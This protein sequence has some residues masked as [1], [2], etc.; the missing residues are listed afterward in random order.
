MRGWLAVAALG[1]VFLTAPA[2]GQRRGGGIS[3]GFAGHGGFASR[4]PAFGGRGM[5]MGN[6]GFGG[7]HQS[8]G[9]GAG[10]R[11]SRYSPGWSSRRWSS[12]GWSR[13][14]YRHGYPWW[15]NGYG[16]Y[17]YPW[18]GGW[19]GD[20][21][22]DWGYPDDS[23]AAQ[24][25]PAYNYPPDSYAQN[26][27]LA[28]QVGR[29]SDEVAR[30]REQRQAQ[31]QA[32]ASTPS[33]APAAAKSEPTELI[34]RDQHTEEVQNYAIVGSTLWILGEQRTRKIALAE[35]DVPATVKA[36][37]DRGVDFQLPR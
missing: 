22:Y 1:A 27:A 7:F 30:L 17:G 13:F 20:L 5:M 12:R 23:Y 33:P 24:S 16:G 34:F 3:R 37:E 31:P 18:W 26:D 32:Q 15:R 19:Y 36:N 25:Y 4:G 8:W 14:N 35:L 21:G 9:R 11:G 2:W 28:E 10:F 29:L 6:R